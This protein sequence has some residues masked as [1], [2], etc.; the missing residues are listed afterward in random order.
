MFGKIE[1][2]QFEGL[3][4]MPQDYASAWSGLEG[5][6]GAQFKP[7]LCLGKQVAKGVDFYFLAE[8][9]LVIHPSLR[10][11]VTLVVNGFNGEY[12]LVHDSVEVVLQ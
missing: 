1:L 3:K 2:E 12:T 9:T 11:V 7:L 6:V 5:I 4:E 10:R 8:Q